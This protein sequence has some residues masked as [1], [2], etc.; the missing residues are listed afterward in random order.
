[1][2]GALARAAAALGAGLAGAG[3]WGW[4]GRTLSGPASHPD[5]GPCWLRLAAAPEDHAYGKTWDGNRDAQRAFGATVRRP[6]L[7]AVHDDSLGG[8]AYRAELSQLIR[9]PILA[10][11]P[12]LRTEPELPGTWWESLRASTGAIAAVSTDRIAVRQEWA[13]RAVPEFLG[14]PAP[15]ITRWATAHGDLHPANLTAGEEPWLLDWEG[16]GMAPVGYDAAMLHAYALMSTGFARHV[17]QAFPVLDAP[18]GRA[19]RVIVVTELLQSASRG[20]HPDLVPA[21]RESVAFLRARA[22]DRGI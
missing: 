16:F 20:D 14:F 2:H 10:P 1:M 12:V 3:M 8:W 17:R 15:R 9:D 7:H 13:D 18:E 6:A 4:R 19:A 21:L 11:E 5:Y 22:S